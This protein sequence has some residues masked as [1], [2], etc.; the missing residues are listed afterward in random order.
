[1]F[2]LLAKTMRY[3]FAIHPERSRRFFSLRV[4]LKEELP[5]SCIWTNQ[6]ETILEE[7]QKQLS[8]SE[9]KG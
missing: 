8:T 7:H 6:L 3:N 2:K 9:E 5:L 4:Q 1:M